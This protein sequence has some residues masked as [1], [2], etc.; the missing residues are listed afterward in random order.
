M[1]TDDLCTIPPR[2]CDVGSSTF[3][4]VIHVLLFGHLEKL[5]DECSTSLRRVCLVGNTMYIS[6]SSQIDIKHKVDLSRERLH[7]DGS[8][9]QLIVGGWCIHPRT[10]VKEWKDVSGGILYIRQHGSAVYV[11][12]AV[13]VCML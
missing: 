9:D 1:P 2:H 12:M 10:M 8:R 11:G 5:V 3:L 4:A 13:V 7:Y 6:S